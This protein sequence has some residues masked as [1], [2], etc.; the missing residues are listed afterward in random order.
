MKKL[1]YIMMILPAIFLAS[2]TGNNETAGEDQEK[3]ADESATKKTIESST[4][5]ISELAKGDE[6]NGMKVTNVNYIKNDSYG[7]E[8]KGK[9][10]VSGRFTM[11]DIDFSLSFVAN[12]LFDKKFV[13]DGNELKMDF[14]EF[15]NVEEVKKA[16]GEEKLNKIN[17]QQDV[18][19]SI[20]VKDFQ[21]SGKMHSEYFSSVE[22]VR[23][24]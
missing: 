6:I 13:I 14:F 8:M 22:F 16:L 3:A 12:D 7:F 19:A 10:T 9:V 23:M 2:C 24:K 21:S 4:I 15:R 11:N 17:N 1:L 20:V 18:K 5:K